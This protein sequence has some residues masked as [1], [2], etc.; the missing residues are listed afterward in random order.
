MCY[1]PDPLDHW[2]E[3]DRQREEE[4]NK[5]PVCD[6]CGE[7]IQEEYCYVI[8]DDYICESCMEENKRSVETLMY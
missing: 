6:S 4:L 3:H 2:L 5:L 8:N 7:H 1:V